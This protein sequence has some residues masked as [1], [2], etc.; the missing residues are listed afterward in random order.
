MTMPRLMK[1]LFL[2]TPVAIAVIGL[3]LV[4]SR[5]VVHAE[6][7]EIGKLNAAAVGVYGTLPGD[8]SEKLYKNDEVFADQL[9]ETVR[10]ANAHIRFE[11]DTDLF[12]GESSTVTLDAF[13][14]DPNVGTGEMVVEIGK[15]LFRFVTGEMPSEAYAVLTPTATI[16]VRGTD[17]TVD[18]S[19]DGSTTVSVIDGIVSVSP[20][21]GGDA[22]SVSAGEVA[23]VATATASVSVSSPPGG[24]SPPAS[25]SGHGDSGGAVGGGGGG[26]GGH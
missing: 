5:T 4:F 26:G 10:R 19:D 6:S 3:A 11:D 16:G 15:G 22:T 12:I 20:R 9:I 24:V 21:G 18:V 2:A 23:A 14:Y 7:T 25:V 8:E 1:L 13:I 17:F